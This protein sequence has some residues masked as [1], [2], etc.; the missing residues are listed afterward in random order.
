MTSSTITTIPAKITTLSELQDYLHLAMQLEHA[1]IPPYLTALYSI[2]PGT[3]ADAVHVLRVVA[4]EEML[5]LTLAANLLNAVGGT[6][7]LTR[8]GFVP[9]YPAY[10]P[11]GE[12]DFQVHIAGFS[13]SALETFLKIERPRSGPGR[14][15]YRSYAPD[16]SVLGAHPG[17]GGAHFYSIGEFYAAIEDG[18]KTL[19]EEAQAQGKTI[20]TGDHAR[21]VTSEYYY[22]GGGKLFP[23]TDLSSACKAINLIMEQGEGIE[24]EIYDNENELAHYYR[25]DQLLKGRYYQKGDKPG[26]PTGPE[27]SVDWDACYKVKEDVKLADMP[28]GTELYVAAQSFNETYAKFLRMLNRAFNG[29]PETLFGAVPRMFE[30]RNLMTELIRNPLPGSNG[31]YAAPT[32]EIAGV[33]RNDA[34]TAAPAAVG[35]VKEVVA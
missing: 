27:L 12:D 33:A 6:P 26:N 20:F 14:L 30:F 13:P 5:H 9:T 11:D 17:G 25:F 2:K 7:D 24:A 19:E 29:E 10:L 32:Y 4:V 28:V 31:L 15:V 23:V 1:T 3:N 18:I 34:P 22:S 35:A 16:A 8:E 21:Q